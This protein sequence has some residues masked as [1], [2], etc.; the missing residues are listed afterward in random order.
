MIR[1]IYRFYIVGT[2]KTSKKLMYYVQSGQMDYNENIMI[3]ITVL[4]M[5][6]SVWLVFNYKKNPNLISNEKN[7]Y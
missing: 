1:A 3:A 2:L 7:N 4:I 6:V 5:V